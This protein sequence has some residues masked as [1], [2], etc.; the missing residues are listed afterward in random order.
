MKTRKHYRLL[1][2]A[3]LVAFATGCS[4]LLDS[5]RAPEQ[6]WWLEPLQASSG[7]ANPGGELTVK[8]TAVPGLDTDRIL[9]I[10][11][12]ARLNHYDGARWPDNA[13]DLLASVLVRSIEANGAFAPVSVR[14]AR[15]TG[16]CHLELELRRYFVE[17]D[18]QDA[19]RSV[20][21][22]MA[23]VLDCGEGSHAISASASVRTTGDRMADIIRAFQEGTDQVSAQ[24]LE[25]LNS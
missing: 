10:N 11:D 8:V 9:N 17:V 16:G 23:G 6:T 12:E 5:E 18:A 21:V 1:C 7:T 13:P 24:I 14:H 22:D 19:P 25:Q 3:L 4:G 20:A 15:P 2:G